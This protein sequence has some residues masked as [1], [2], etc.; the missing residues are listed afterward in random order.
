MLSRLGQ[1]V[2]AGAVVVLAAVAAVGL[3]QGYRAAQLLAAADDPARLSDVALEGRFDAATAEREIDAALAAGDP[4]LAASFVELARDRAVKL[5]P[6]QVAAVED[7]VARE[8]APAAGARRFAHGLVTGEPDDLAGLAGAATGDLF[9]FGDVRDA[10]REGVRMARGEEV[11]ELILGL[12]CVGLTVTAA[13]YATAGVGAPARVGLSVLKAARRT[14]RLGTRLGEGLVRAVRASIDGPAL[15]EGVRHAVLQPALAVRSVRAAVKTDKMRGL[16]RM[17]G[18]VGRIQGKAG[19][20]AALDAVKLADEP[21]DVAR[22]A[23]LADAK[24]GKTRAVL[25]ILG[26]GAIM[27]TTGL[28]ELATAV[29]AAIL[30]VIGFCAAVKATTERL[31]LRAIRRRKQHR[32][33]QQARAALLAGA[34]AAG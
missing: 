31:A 12:A 1:R 10:L 33:A 3:P 13:T 25:K 2:A 21:K 5:D 8:A 27:L 30:N 17:V 14:G 19:T 20:R 29:L 15:R 4:E 32:A 23:R 26:R 22:L 34:A 6:A 24:G 28:F 7:A 9:V 16:V 18:D 11:D